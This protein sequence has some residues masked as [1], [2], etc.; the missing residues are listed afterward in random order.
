MT[1]QSIFYEH[2]TTFKKRKNFESRLEPHSHSQ[3]RAFLALEKKRRQGLGSPT[4]TQKRRLERDVLQAL[5]HP[6]E[7]EKLLFLAMVPAATNEEKG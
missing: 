7:E 4:N 1:N 6:M 3:T 5:S 2:K